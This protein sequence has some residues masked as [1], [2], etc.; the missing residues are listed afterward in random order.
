VSTKDTNQKKILITG[1]VKN[2]EKTLFEDL[3]TLKLALSP[4][5][6][7]YWF[8]V[9]S[10]SSDESVRSLGSFSTT[11]K[12]FSFVTLG[13]L[14]EPGVSRTVGMAHARNQYLKEIRENPK[15]EGIDYVAIADFN[16]LNDRLSF[17]SVKSCFERFDWDACFANQ[18]GRYYDIWALRHP[19]WSPNDCWEQLDFY[20]KYIKFPEKAL[21]ISLESRMIRIPRNSEWI[22]VESAFGGFGIYKREAL[23][24]G[25]YAGLNKNGSPV[26]EHV[27]FHASLVQSD[28]KLFIN[29]K[30]INAKSTDHSLRMNFLNSILRIS[31]YP[32]KILKRKFSGY[33]KT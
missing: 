16:Q 26:C 33:V 14:N 18:S 19:L 22:Q 29:P 5:G 17:E 27:P 20:R 1:I 13:N 7:L 28:K 9:E 24:T 4:I 30:L 32:E 10:D 31:K 21:R 25:E 23:L 11:E 8:L 12:N 2:I 15:F 3:E 6:E